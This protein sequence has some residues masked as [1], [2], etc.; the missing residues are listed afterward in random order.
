MTT[1]GYGDLFPSNTKVYYA[2]MAEGFVS[3]IL[4]S[5]FVA[6]TGK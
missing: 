5:V 4:T 1:V 2:A 3:L 6:G